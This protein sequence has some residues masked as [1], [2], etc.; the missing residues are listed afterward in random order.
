MEEIKISM[1]WSELDNLLFFT[2]V[3]LNL[4]GVSTRQRMEVKF[5]LEKFFASTMSAV[6]MTC[7]I[8]AGAQRLAVKVDGA[9]KQMNFSGLEGL[10]QASGLTLSPGP[11]ACMIQ[12]K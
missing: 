2:D 9:K 1:D 4:A 6:S 12:W 3:R 8:D 5:I 11:N 10:A 7:R